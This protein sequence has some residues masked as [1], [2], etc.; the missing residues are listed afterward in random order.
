MKMN[1]YNF[2]C[3]TRRVPLYYVA[4]LY[5]VVA[6]LTDDAT[7]AFCFLV[8]GHELYSTKD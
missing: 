3:L 6:G 1:W 7:S 2:F 5:L 8:Q 4:K